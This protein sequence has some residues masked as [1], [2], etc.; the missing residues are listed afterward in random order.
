M[1]HLA[2][3]EEYTQGKYIPN[4]SQNIHGMAHCLPNPEASVDNIFFLFPYLS[5]FKTK[6][7][8]YFALC[9]FFDFGQVCHFL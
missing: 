2:K 4:Y 1:A 9:I 8:M 7:G 5:S 3:V 6:L